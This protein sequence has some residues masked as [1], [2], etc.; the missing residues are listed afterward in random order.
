MTCYNVPTI[1]EV[2]AVTSPAVSYPT[3]E[4]FVANLMSKL[5]SFNESGKDYLAYLAS[6]RSGDELNIRTSL[7][8]AIFQTLGWN[9]G[10]LPSDIDH[11]IGNK[12]GKR[13]DIIAKLAGTDIKFFI[14]ETK[15]TSDPHLDAA[16]ANF[17]QLA[18]Y[19]KSDGVPL[20]I[21]TNMVLLNAWRFNP[22][23]TYVEVASLDLAAIY[24]QYRAGGLASLNSIQEYELRRFWQQFSKQVF[25]GLDAIRALIYVNPYRPVNQRE[26]EQAL[27]DDLRRLTDDLL[28]DA[29]QQFDQQQA[30]YLTYET[31][32]RYLD[33]A[34]AQEAE[35]TLASLRQLARDEVAQAFPARAAAV[36]A[37]LTDF[38]E[39]YRQQ[40][41]VSDL[42]ADLW[43]TAHPTAARHAAPDS[44]Y[45]RAT[46]K[47]ARTYLNYQK[48]LRR[49]DARNEQ[50]RR[51]RAAFDYWL[52][53]A[54]ANPTTA[55]EDFCLQTVYVQVVRL[56]LVRICEDKKLL[57]WMISDGGFSLFDGTVKDRF[58][59]LLKD[60]YNQLLSLAYQNTRSIYAHFFYSSGLFDWYTSDENILL[61]AFATLNQYNFAEVNSDI[62]GVVY[63]GY[64]IKK[65]RKLTGQYYTPGEV[66]DYILDATGYTAEG[67]IIGKTLL[68]LACGSG[69]FLVAATNRLVAAY[70]ATGV[71]QPREIIERVI[72]SV[73]GF[74]LNPFACYLAEVNLLVQLVDLIQQARAADPSFTIRR[75]QIYRSDSLRL[76][77]SNGNGNGIQ[78]A[79]D[80]ELE[81]YFS[82]EFDAIERIM[83]LDKEVIAGGGFD[84]VVGNPPYGAQL[85]D[86]T[87]RYLAAHYLTAEDRFDTYAAFI[88]RGLDMLKPGGKLG[89]ITPQTWTTHKIYGKLRYLV[90]ATTNIEDMVQVWKIF[91]AASVNSLIFALKK[92]ANKAD[93][94]KSDFDPT[95]PD[96]ISPQAGAVTIKL[97]PETLPALAGVK[98][99]PNAIE[100]RRTMLATGDWQVTISTPQADWWQ[101]D[102][103]YV[104]NLNVDASKLAILQKIESDTIHFED[105]AEVSTG[106]QEYAVGTGTP[107]QTASMLP[108]PEH[109]KPLGYYHATTKLDESYRAE[110]Q[111][112]E[113]SLYYLHSSNQLWLKWGPNLTR[114]RPARIWEQPKLVVH[115]LTGGM[116][117]RLRAAYDEQNYLTPT[118][119]YAVVQRD[120]AYS[121][122]Y[123]LAL[124]NSR[125]FN[126]YFAA[127]HT[128]MTVKNYHLNALPV[129]P[130]T[131]EQQQPFVA[132]AERLI[133]LNHAV[134]AYRDAGYR[135][136]LDSG[137]VVPPVRKLVGGFGAANLLDLRD[138]AVQGL[139]S[140]VASDKTL[141]LPIKRLA[142][143]AAG[144]SKLLLRQQDEI[145]ISGDDALIDYLADALAEQQAQ[146]DGKTWAE[147]AAAVRL[148]RDE[149][150]A[151]RGLAAVQH[152][153]AA[154]AA[155]LA[156][157]AQLSTEVDAL[158]CQL[159]GLDAAEVATV[160][161]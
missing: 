46:L 58:M 156:E 153:R 137:L 27:V 75:F 74:D 126:W 159:Y 146:L 49:L 160:L 13:P 47:Y 93:L 18:G 120:P 105:V 88:E 48:R 2:S 38:E 54:E 123:L 28:A 135:I 55:R 76:P 56:L 87:K 82:D 39:R 72:Q 143:A 100:R 86:K 8:F 16:S 11:D 80:L 29:Y 32:G 112:D 161:R 97:L 104:F 118:T 140:V 132:L 124:L 116:R 69:K 23:G 83:S 131:A 96:S 17:G 35:A 121:L 59:R 7:G 53:V 94:F 133:S 134:G 43:R 31:A 40:P 64:I 122:K 119:L 148:P 109:G 101:P 52:D 81:A 62:I 68:D 92:Q 44:N 99:P 91:D 138:A 9:F 61:R 73:Y 33:D 117:Y 51:F 71:Y 152:A 3:Y 67:G 149:A 85:S 154:V 136:N 1:L 45:F 90:L 14:V 158:V 127:K 4:Q 147:V 157:I 26:H 89:Y 110:L 66:V 24:R 130:L 150:T 70:L 41:S 6:P 84:F 60:A 128:D 95:A 114:P 111:T 65:A 25:A 21:L 63:E 57:G 141:R 5:D 15:A 42:L 10:G 115:R 22:D 139:I 30:A 129:K 125:L 151:H 12:G 106:I 19:I 79:D 78:F 20:G 102:N 113:V 50:P 98:N 145:S 34:R 142:G 107:K 108:D 155:Q 144:Q 36:L 77:A 103:N 37:V